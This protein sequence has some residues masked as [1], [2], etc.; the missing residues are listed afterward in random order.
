LDQALEGILSPQSTQTKYL[1]P[2]IPVHE[3]SIHDSKHISLANKLI[4]P[5]PHIS[6]NNGT[7]TPKIIQTI[8]PGLECAGV[9]P[10]Y[11]SL[12]MNGFLLCRYSIAISYA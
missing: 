11:P 10:T 12:E 6:Q 5:L 1:L 3:F 2:R 7:I 9:R 4:F 8:S